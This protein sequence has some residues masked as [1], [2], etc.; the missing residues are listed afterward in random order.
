[1]ASF[2]DLRPYARSAKAECRAALSFRRLASLPTAY[3]V[4]P[5][6]AFNAVSELATLRGQKAFDASTFLTRTHGPFSSL[7]FL[8][9]KSA[10]N[11]SVS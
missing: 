7:A 2:P 9:R 10:C 1:M 8:V 3:A 11:G 6:L 5:T 4:A